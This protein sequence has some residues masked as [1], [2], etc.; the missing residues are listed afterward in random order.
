MASVSTDKNGNR[1]IKFWD[2]E[3]I[4]RGVR[5]GKVDRKTAERLCRDVEELLAARKTGQPVHAQTADNLDRLDKC[6]RRR[7]EK[8]GLLEPPPRETPVM[9]LGSFLA[10]YVAG[11]GDLKR[12]TIDNL[13]QAVAALNDY[14][15]ADRPLGAVTAGDADEFRNWLQTRRKRPLAAN[16]ARRL[17]SRAKQFFRHALKKKLVAENPFAGM[18]GLQVRGNE[19]RRRFITPEVTSRVLG[20]CPSLDWRVIVAL[21][22]YGGLRPSEACNLRWEHVDWHRERIRIRCEKTHHHEGR[23]W[24][25]IPFFPELM[26]HI[27]EAWE[28]AAAGAEMVV[29]Q[30]RAHQNLGPVLKKIIA[31]AGLEVW[32][33]PF[34][35]LRSTRETEL[36]KE[37]PIHVVCSWLGN[38]NRVAMEHYLQV[39]D[40]DY[41][42]AAAGGVAVSAE[43]KKPQRTAEAE[44]RPSGPKSGPAGSAS[45]GRQRN[46][47]KSPQAADDEIAVLDAW[48]RSG[49]SRSASPDESQNSPSRI[50]TYNLPVNS[51][52][53]YR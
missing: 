8:A 38:T 49:Q 6:L 30:Y 27:H 5:L 18:R 15:G 43:A 23:E 41:R 45:G 10:A 9:P 40:E 37:Y 29:V 14:F 4:Q 22:R 12:S 51:R 48:C 7:F 20:A 34:Q 28:A 53:L 21:C 19:A 24:R 26:V 32:P 46:G 39:T 44:R 17:C 42:R 13:R 50:R 33:K 47:A 35:N 31:K 36:A 1:R 3:G 16:T 2:R 52:P 25:E 11:R